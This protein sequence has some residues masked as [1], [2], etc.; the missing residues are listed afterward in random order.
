MSHRTFIPPL[1]TGFDQFGQ[2]KAGSVLTRF[3]AALGVLGP[4]TIVPGPDMAAVP[5]CAVAACLRDALRTVGG[6]TAGLLVRGALTVGSPWRTGPVSKALNPKSTIFCTGLLP[7]PPPSHLSAARA[8]MLL[9]LLHT[10]RTLPL[11]W[12]GSY[13]LLLSKARHVLEEPRTRR[14]RSGG[15]RASR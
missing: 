14:A 15:P 5:Q 8:M 2:E 12:L 11:A 9:V 1:P 6:I 4:L 13:V 10:T 3:T 7:T